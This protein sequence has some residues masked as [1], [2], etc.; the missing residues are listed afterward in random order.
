MLKLH[1]TFHVS[2]L[3]PCHDDHHHLERNQSRR[4]APTV[5]KK[6]TQMAEKIMDQV[7]RQS[8]KN[9]QTYFLVQWKNLPQSKASWEKDTT[10]WQFEELIQKFLQAQP[11]MASGFSSGEGL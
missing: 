10:L 1:P 8:K 6:F 4:A 5:R 2:F 3:K 11:T 9:R 7:E